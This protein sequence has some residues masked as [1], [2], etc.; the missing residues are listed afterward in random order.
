[1]WIPC[2]VQMESRWILYKI[3]DCGL[4][5]MESTWNLWVRV[6]YTLATSRKFQ[7]SR[8]HPST[9][10]T[11][12]PINSTWCRMWAGKWGCHATIVQCC[13][14]FLQPPPALAASILLVIRHSLLFTHVLLVSNSFLPYV[15]L[16][17]SV[18]HRL[19]TISHANSISLTWLMVALYLFIVLNISRIF[20]VSIFYIYTE[21]SQSQ[22]SHCWIYFFG[23]NKSFK[24]QDS[25][26][27]IFYVFRAE[28]F[29][30]A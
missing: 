4:F 5:H 11:C 9:L 15:K 23:L 8:V 10:S 24:C 26:F 21:M 6:K 29:L 1:M 30:W 13:S 3:V 27:N 28:Y 12:P 22:L 2:G 18:T 20:T 25:E 14:C 16:F 19:L 17:T 7:I